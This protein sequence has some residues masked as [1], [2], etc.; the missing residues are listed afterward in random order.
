MAM[1]RVDTKAKIDAEAEK[2]P[3]PA[4]TDANKPMMPTP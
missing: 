3:D 4:A 2:R 1:Q